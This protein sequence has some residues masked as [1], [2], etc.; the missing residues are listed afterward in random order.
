MTTEVKNS[1]RQELL[2]SVFPLKTWQGGVGT[3]APGHYSFPFTFAV[4]EW[5]PASVLFAEN[6]NNCER[7]EISYTLSA[8]FVPARHQDWADAKQTVS[9]F[10]GEIPVYIFRPAYEIQARNLK[11]NLKSKVGGLLGFGKSDCVTD[12]IFDKNEY[13]LGDKAK[14]KIICDNSKCSKAVRGFK[15]KLH[16]KIFGRANI[17]KPPTTTTVSEYVFQIKEEG[18]P[19]KQKVEREFEV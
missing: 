9:L 6:K 19:A 1:G 15:F 17:T 14:I 5:L 10:R 4:P 18:S 3:S 16:R 7:F 13:Y 11:F 2:K 8:Q 12:I